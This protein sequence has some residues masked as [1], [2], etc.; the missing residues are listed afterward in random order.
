MCTMINNSI[1]CMNMNLVHE[2]S[3]ITSILLVGVEVMKCLILIFSMKDS[4]QYRASGI[5]NCQIYA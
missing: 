4:F 2:N 1:K 3:K 5:N